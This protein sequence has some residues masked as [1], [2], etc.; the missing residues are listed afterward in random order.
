MFCLLSKLKAGPRS[1]SMATFLI[2]IL[3]LLV[4]NFHFSA[5]FLLT[6]HYGRSSSLSCN[7]CVC[8]THKHEFHLLAPNIFLF[9]VQCLRYYEYVNILISN[10][11]CN[12]VVL[13]LQYKVFVYSRVNKCLFFFFLLHCFF[14]YFASFFA[15]CFFCFM[16]LKKITS[17]SKNP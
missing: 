3:I 11:W 12:K 5:I 17:S 15:S 7:S 2:N 8:S 1:P 10:I 4:L 13:L 16:Y 14:F 6:F 9:H